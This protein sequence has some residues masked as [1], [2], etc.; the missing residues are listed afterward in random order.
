M[1][2]FGLILGITILLFVLAGYTDGTSMDAKWNVSGWSIALGVVGV[3]V[4][5]SYVLIRIRSASWWPK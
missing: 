3:V 2:A 4:L 1:K 5:L